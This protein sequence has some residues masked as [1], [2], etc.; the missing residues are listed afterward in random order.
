M[1]TLAGDFTSRGLGYVTIILAAR[2]LG[3]ETFGRYTLAATFVG[4][5]IVL[6]EFGLQNLLV[7]EIARQPA[8]SAKYVA[9]AC[10]LGI[11][12]ATLSHGAIISA[13]VAF[14]WPAEA[15]IT[16]AV[17]GLALW[18][19]AFST[20][21][22]AALRGTMQLTEVALINGITG[23]ILLTATIWMLSQRYG[24][25]GVAWAMALAAGARLVLSVRLAQHGELLHGVTSGLDWSLCRRLWQDALPFAL[26]SIAVMIYFRVDIILL[27]VLKGEATVGWYAAAYRILDAAMIIPGAIVAVLYPLLARLDAS[28]AHR[29][30][31]RSQVALFLLS[32]PLAAA[33]TYFAG[34]LTLFLYGPEYAVAAPVLQVLIWAIIP[35]FL[36]AALAYGLY[37]AGRST[38]VSMVNWLNIPLNVGLNWA[39][40]PALGMY[41]AALSTIL[42]E[43]FSLLC[44]TRASH[45]IREV[46]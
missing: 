17:L 18:A 16:V 40:I 35:I 11:V 42:C 12:L 22:L 37:A 36:N 8:L 21:C 15:G 30:R 7:R 29:L 10:V 38:L 25:V 19:N 2:W 41:G 3:S 44:Y 9:A 31:L 45:G 27:S 26:T 23:G 43:L 5:F 4:Y 1:M 46:G 28:K 6:A 33:V 39:L 13:A 14:G 32:L 34:P 20:P 24:M